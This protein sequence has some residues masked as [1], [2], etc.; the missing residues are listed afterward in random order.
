MHKIAPFI[1]IPN[2]AKEVRDYYASIFGENFFVHDGDEKFENTPSGG[3]VV[4]TMTIHDQLFRVMCTELPHDDFT[5]SVSFELN[6]KDQ[7]E[8]DKYWDAL[9]REGE[10]SQCGWC[11]DKYGVRWQVVPENISE[12]VSTPDQMQVMME[13]QKLIISELEAAGKA[14]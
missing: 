12:L 1:W 4:F 2:D 14:V 5:D 8:V 11:R 13:M 3:I 10:E 6:C 9:T 7:A